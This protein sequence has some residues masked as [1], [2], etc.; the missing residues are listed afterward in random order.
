MFCVPSK[1]KAY[2]R[3]QWLHNAGH[4]DEDL[5][6]DARICVVSNGLI[7]KISLDTLLCCTFLFMFSYKHA[8]Q[9][10]P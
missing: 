3:T 6:K 8:L 7:I 5:P 10:A 2:K 4:K 9:L 1:S